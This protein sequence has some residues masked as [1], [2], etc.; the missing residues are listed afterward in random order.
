MRCGYRLMMYEPPAGR[1]LRLNAHDQSHLGQV[2]INVIWQEGRLT[3]YVKI[4]VTPMSIP[5]IHNSHA[6]LSLETRRE[7]PYL[8]E[9]SLGYGRPIE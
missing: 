5:A 7:Y 6:E 9:A 4:V 3:L 1:I 2:L 8:D